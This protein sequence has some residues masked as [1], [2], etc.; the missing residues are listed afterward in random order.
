M[1]PAR[2]R[3]PASQQI[4]IARNRSFPSPPPAG[5]GPSRHPHRRLPR[6][7]WSVLNAQCRMKDPQCPGNV[8]KHPLTTSSAKVVILD[9]QHAG[10]A[11]LVPAS[12]RL[13][14]ARSRSRRS[15]A[16]RLRVGGIGGCRS[17]SGHAV[18]R[19]YSRC[20]SA[21][22]SRVP[23]ARARTVDWP[24]R[25]AM[26][27]PPSRP[28][29]RYSL[30]LERSR[31]LPASNA[32]PSTCRPRRRHF[33]RAMTRRSTFDEGRSPAEVPGRTWCPEGL[34]HAPLQHTAAPAHLPGH[35]VNRENHLARSGAEL[36]RLVQPGHHQPDARRSSRWT[37]KTGRLTQRSVEGSLGSFWH[38][39][40]RWSSR[41]RRLGLV[42]PV[43][44]RRRE[45]WRWLHG[46]QI[47]EGGVK[48]GRR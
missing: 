20:R 7:R 25:S 22:T 45:I 14:G 15:S 39:R 30:D 28:R 18:D 3:T 17:F 9:H 46:R 37:S 12:R 31:R 32:R 6:G 33:S 35:L 13:T 47:F 21:A 41:R 43:L 24:Y 26:P 29:P 19:R 38:D 1:D 5:T 8:L 11:V 36:L 48:A 42:G 4:V 44:D 16:R 10:L 27:R 23:P 34:A 40:E 2:S